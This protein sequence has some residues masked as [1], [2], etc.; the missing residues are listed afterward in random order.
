MQYR[1]PLE[2][3]N[4]CKKSETYFR[5]QRWGGK[6]YCPGC[7]YRRKLYSLSDGRFQCARCSFK[8][9]EFTGTYLENL[10]IG[11][12]ELSHLL[13]LFVLGVP[14]YRCR[15]YLS[16]SLKTAQKLYTLFRQAIY[17]HCMIQLREIMLEG[18]IEVDES[19]YGG[20]HKG[21]R[22][23]GAAGKHI[24]FGLYQR[25]GHVVTFPVPDRSTSALLPLVLQYTKPG[26]LYYSD[27]WHA[28]TKLSIKGD[29]VVI[30]KHKGKPRAKGRDHI[31]CI[32]GFWSF[33]KNWMYQYRGIPKHHFHL[34][35]KETEF[36]FNYRKRDLF[37]EISTLLTLNLSPV[38][39]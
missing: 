29:H 2:L 3:A 20:H 9:R 26:C 13:Y 21:K 38:S 14:S 22:G 17:D 7:G 34:Y 32:E 27:D 6:R 4:S 5:A 15:V 8:F 1:Q 12:D 30:D 10:R 19:M 23:W 37:K 25:N 31:N 16:V 18:E 24:V 35:L 39:S 11:F 28:Y 36:R 33:S